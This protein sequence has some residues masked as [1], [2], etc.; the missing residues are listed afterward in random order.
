MNRSLQ[1][2]IA[3]ALVSTGLYMYQNSKKPAAPL[4]TTVRLGISAD[5]PPFTFV[6]NGEFV[7]FEL[8]LAQ[9]LA[10]ELKYN[11]D[12]LDLDF[13][14][15]IAAVKNDVIDL[16]IS[17]F[18]ITEERKK[19]IAFSQPYYYSN[20]AVIGHKAY[21]S[22]DEFPT[23][24]IGLQHGSLFEATGKN[25]QEKFPGITILGFHRINQA[26]QELEDKTIDLILIDA[27]V[28]KQI[29][30]THPALI[31]SSLAIHDESNGLG[32][33]FKK[34]SPL[35]EKFNTAIAAI[36]V[37]GTLDKLIEK[38]FSSAEPLT[39]TDKE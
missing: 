8:D 17:G 7:G 29:I 23:A 5:N 11:L 36:K 25:L 27:A 24:K 28:A 35:V 31:V 38:W 15:L 3:L 20:I 12:V 6:K 1:L 33:I 19:N 26:V 39:P 34:E 22:A 2:I 18:N 37:N 4:G 9:A 30:A 16:S 32:A 13:S 21:S 10:S 14:G